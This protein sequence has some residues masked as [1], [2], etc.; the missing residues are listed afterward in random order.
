[1]DKLRNSH[2]NEAFTEHFQCPVGFADFHLEGVRSD[3]PGFFRFGK[4]LVCYGRSTSSQ[5]RSTRGGSLPDLEECVRIK[6]SH[7]ALPFDPTEVV[8]SMRREKYV[9]RHGGGEWKRRVNKLKRD[10]YYFM[11]PLLG[12]P[13]RKHL[14]RVS[15]KGW[16]EK[17]FPR[18]PV[19]RSVDQ[20]FEQLLAWSL[21][22]Q[23]V[24]AIPFIWFW[25]EG[26]K[27]CAIVTHDVEEEAGLNNCSSLMETD[28]SFGIKSSFQFIPEKRY[29]LRKELMSRLRASGFEVNIHDLNHDGHLYDNR[30]EFLRKATKINTYMKEY[31]AAGFRAGALYRNL[32][33]YDAFEFSYDM[34][35]PNVGHLD[36]QPGGC[37]TL[38]PYFVGQILEIPLT[39]TQDYS[40]FHVIRDYT[41]DLW[42]HQATFIA[43]NHGLISFNVHPD[44][45]VERRASD[46]YRA[47]LQYLSTFRSENNAWVCLP[48]EV[49]RWWRERSQMR[50]A[51]GPDGNWRIEGPGK[52]RARLAFAH[53]D[54]DSVVYDVQG[55]TTE[56]AWPVL[57][58]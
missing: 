2:V 49:D 52:E 16:Q 36:P 56:V 41:I 1:M 12:V 55:S 54:G 43:E 57:V 17:L 46:T 40:L 34:S 50:V 39:T 51:K 27:C 7:C 21:R 14:Q 33:W 13:V 3:A 5:S 19:D 15:L 48:G 25:P 32:D 38:M 20:L 28:D 10:A 42:Q 53:L 45:L 37:C 9:T 22:S 11:R 30:D 47:L 31:G 58:R 29:A 44:Y 18:W 8:A 26:H 24:D 23:G 6:K 35:V 4:D